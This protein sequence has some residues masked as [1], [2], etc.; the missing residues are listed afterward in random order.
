MNVL[1]TGGCG[2]IGSHTAIALHNA[3]F[4]FVLLD[5]F[6]NSKESIIGIIENIINKKVD[7]IRGDIRDSVLVKNIIKGHEIKC[8]IHLAGE[9]SPNESIALPINYYSSNVEGAISLIKAMENTDVRSLIFS[10]SAAVYGEPQY[11][12]IDELHP[13]SPINPYGRTKL[14]V[15]EMLKDLAA[16]DPRWKIICLRYFNPV[17]GH[18]STYLGDVPK[19]APSNLIPNISMVVE[20][21]LP[22]LQIYG[23]DFDT[24]DGFGVRDF[25]HIMDLA[26]GHSSALNALDR[27]SGWHTFNLGTG[28]GHSVLEVIKEYEKVCGKTIKFSICAR[29]PGDVAI[30]YADVSKV[31]ALLNWSAKYNLL[32]MC[33]SQ[34]KLKRSTY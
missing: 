18:D 22:E 33:S 34:H 11:Y 17:G 30:S 25:I 15:E 4:K 12:P 28:C 5:N 3:G 9:K 8:V 14:M 19:V 16:S 31:K 32:E 20:G 24:P 26:E 2:Y 1:L 10:S 21:A 27:L 7:Y 23:G 29:R 6:F 13:R